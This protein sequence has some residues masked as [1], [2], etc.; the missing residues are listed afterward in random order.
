MNRKILVTILSLELFYA[1]SP[2]YK[3]A[4]PIGGIKAIEEKLYYTD[5]ARLVKTEGKILVKFIVKPD[6]SVEN[7]ELLSIR[8]GLDEIAVEAVKNASSKLEI[9]VDCG[10]KSRCRYFSYNNAK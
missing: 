7:V 4:E 1:C 3:F 5:E 6:S 10:W 2:A 8:F 9:E